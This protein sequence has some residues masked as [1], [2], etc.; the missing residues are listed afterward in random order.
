MMLRSKYKWNILSNEFIES[1]EGLKTILLQN[2][3]IDPSDSERFLFGRPYFHSPFLFQDMEKVVKR[4]QEAIENQ[5]KVMIYGDYDVD[6]V[7]GSAILYKALKQLGL[8]HL[9]CY[10]PNR[11]TEGYGPNLDAFKKFVK[12]KVNLVITV[13]N[14]ITGIEEAILLKEAGIDLIITDHHEAKEVIPDAFAII[15]PSLVNETY[16]F[17]ELSGAGVSFKV[18]HALLD[19]VPEELS[20][21]AALG[22]YA[23]IVSVRGENRSILKLGM[24]QIHYTIN[25]GL[26]ILKD[27]AKV[28]VINEFTLGFILGPRLNAPGRM[29]TALDA[30]QLLI[31]ENVNEVVQLANQIESQNQER[32]E[33]IEEIMDEAHDMIRRDQLDHYHVLVLASDTWHEGVLGI[34]ASRLVDAY[35][36][37]AIVLA[38]NDEVY[39]GS[40]RTLDGFS[41]FDHLSQLSHLLIKFGGHKMAAGLSIEK[42]QIEPFRNELHLLADCDLSQSI[43]IE[44]ILNPHLIQSS[45]FDMIDIFRPFGVD[46]AHPLFLFKGVEISNLKQMGSDCKHL[47]FTIHQDRMRIDV[48]GFS[49]GTLF[50][51][52]ENGDLVDVVGSVEVNVFNGQSN[53]QIHLKDLAINQIRILDYRNKYF[54]INSLDTKNVQFI[55]FNKPYEFEETVPFSEV[56][57]FSNQLFLIDL[58]ND[59]AQLKNILNQKNV[60]KVYL[61]FKD[62]HL[63]SM[64]HILTREKMIQIYSVYRKYKTFTLEDKRVINH[65]NQLG[66]NKKIHLLSIQVFF[67][68]NF[69]IIDGKE[70]RVVEKPS[71]RELHESTTFQRLQENIEMR[72]RLSLSSTQELKEYLLS[73]ITEE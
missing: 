17:K 27:V 64:E 44:G 15:H 23:D 30:V 50:H 7:T 26:R 53:Y 18:A 34:V 38:L 66:F 71:K 29:D 39:K 48:V 22:T 13:D 11:F 2:R 37:P 49:C 63:F 65:L 6:G 67:E 61:L 51:D 46:N 58:P 42:D 68:L 35:G 43:N 52:L 47:K 5:E 32:K 62:E 41:L 28:D 40:A 45:F 54:N 31:S 14:G 25:L 57:H 36:K 4:I 55:Y 8:N 1:L 69:V 16:P 33:T 9:N 21:L 56:T 60:R 19:K 3:K 72:E 59:V 12:E 70:V 20:D 24:N 73:L 10:I